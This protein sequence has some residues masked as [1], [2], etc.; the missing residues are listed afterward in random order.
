MRNMSAAALNAILAESAGEVVLAL[1]RVFPPGE[2]NPSNALRFVDD[3][4]DGAVISAGLE[5]TPL[6]F[7]LVLPQ[8]D[9]ERLP[10]V[11]ITIDNVGFDITTAILTY[12]GR[13]AVEIEF[14]LASTPSVVEAGPWRFY[15]GQADISDTEI[16]L[17]LR[18]EDVL[19]DAFPGH[20]FT[21]QNF[22]G[23]FTR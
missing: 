5:Y 9:G 4:S 14:V 10:T 20:R 21:P 18:Y 16:S 7:R 17:D 2:T 22:P 3:A 23:L 1:L 11:S 8:E 13:A 19:N 15:V 12:T 6:A